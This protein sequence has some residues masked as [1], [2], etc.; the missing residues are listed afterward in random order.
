M[1]PLLQTAFGVPTALV[2][3]GSGLA[4]TTR[5]DVAVQTPLV[6]VIV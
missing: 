2:I 1:V 3:I 5:V 4:V 6:P